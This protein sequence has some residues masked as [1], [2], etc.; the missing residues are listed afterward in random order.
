MG[1][2]SLGLHLAVRGYLDDARA[3]VQHFGD[4]KSPYESGLG[5]A[6]AWL[7]GFIRANQRFRDRLPLWPNL[8]RRVNLP[9]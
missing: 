4:F 8:L 2:A 3:C 1:R 7:V 6:L 5:A 9:S